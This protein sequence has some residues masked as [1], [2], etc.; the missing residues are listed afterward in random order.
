VAIVVGIIRTDLREADFNTVLKALLILS[1]FLACFGI[2]EFLLKGNPI[3]SYL[4]TKESLEW[5]AAYYR[6]TTVS[7]YRIFTL[8]GHPL[9]NASLFLV[10]FIPCYEENQDLFDSFVYDCKSVVIFTNK[11]RSNPLLLLLFICLKAQKAIG[12]R[13]LLI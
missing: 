7:P 4:R 10:F 1:C 8:M 2:C 6:G 11:Y 12:M 5:H 3:F 13:F 9:E